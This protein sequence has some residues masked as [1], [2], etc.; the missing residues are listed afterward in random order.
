MAKYGVHA[1]GSGRSTNVVQLH[2]RPEIGPSGDGNMYCFSVPSSYLVFRRNGCVFV[3]GNTGKSAILI[4]TFGYLFEEEK[5]DAVVYIAKKGEYGN[6]ARY[7]IP[8]HLPDRIGREVLVYS[9]HAAKTKT[10]QQ[11]LKSLLK[12]NKDRLPIFV[13][14]VEGLIHGAS[15][16]LDLFYDNNKKVFFVLDEST[17]AKHYDSQRSKRV[18]YWASKSLYRRIATGTPVTQAP[19]DLFGQSLVLGKSTLGFTSFY[20]FRNTYCKLEMQYLGNRS[21][22]KVVGYK[23]LEDLTKRVSSFS[24][25]I[26]KTDCLDLPPKVYTQ[27]IIPLTEKQAKLY[28]ELRDEAMLTLEGHELEVINVLSQITKLQQIVCGQLKVGDSEY[29]SIE[30]NR[31]DALVELLEDYPGKAV[32]WAAFRQSLA[33]IVSTLQEKFGKKS[34]VGYYGG[35]SDADRKENVNRFKGW[36]PVMENGQMIGREEITVEDQARFIVANQAMG[37]GN[38]WT[39]AELV[40]YYANSYNLEH[41]LQSEDRTHRIGQT[42]TVVYVD[43]FTPD[44]VEERVVEVLRAKKS[45]ADEIMARPKTAWL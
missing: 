29:V 20:A 27:R 18:Y 12:P 7:E 1:I 45:L 26:L 32:I 21:F 31:L 25:R 11:Q 36:R 33:D 2:C 16:Q 3:S 19:A 35:V 28:A 6:F 4:N 5:I 22:Q 41:R 40:I 15:S 14:N 30:N 13:V 24:H 44:T 39:E 42:K 8:A 9:A 37:F 43:M 17:C 34:T 23:N 10:Y 38:T